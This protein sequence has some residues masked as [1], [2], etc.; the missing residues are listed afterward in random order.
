MQ[1]NLTEDS[2]ERISDCK[3]YNETEEEFVNKLIRKEC[4][5]KKEQKQR[6]IFDTVMIIAMIIAII[7]S[8]VCI[9][10]LTT[11]PKPP[12]QN[13]PM[14]ISATNISPY[15]TEYQKTTFDANVV[16]YIDSF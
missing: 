10:K 3:K 5:T 16:F 14:V 4:Y 1:I 11:T 6:A 15:I 12:V 8:I 7:L 9:V 2:L 13:S